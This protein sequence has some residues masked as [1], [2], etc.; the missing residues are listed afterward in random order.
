MVNRF[1]G[2]IYPAVALLAT[3]TATGRTEGQMDPEAWLRETEEAYAEAT[4]YTARFHKQQRVAG[5]LLHKE[6][7][8]IKFRRPFSLYM[9]WIA[10]P[11]EGSELLYVQGWNENLARVHKGGFFR[12][13]TRNL[14]PTN[15]RLMSS[16][17]RPLTDMGID[18]FL[19]TVAVNV[20]KAVKAGE[21]SVHERGEEP[22]YGRKTHIFEVVFPKDRTKGYDAYR[23]IIN[24]DIES[25]ILI[26]IQLYDWDDHPFE[27]YGYEDLKLNAGLTDADFDPENPDYH[28]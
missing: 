2:M 11:N 7:I 8:L 18:F 10:A 3:M 9:R 19:K 28:F 20:R 16:N 27:L 24:R 13:I 1:T 5:T 17:L 26:R 22:V 12:F 15:P 14:D 6:T 4:N 25:K 23:M 21:L